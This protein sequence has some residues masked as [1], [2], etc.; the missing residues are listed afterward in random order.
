[1]TLRYVYAKKAPWVL[2]T[3]DAKAALNALYY[4]RHGRFGNLIVDSSPD[5]PA[6][7]KAAVLHRSQVFRSHV[8][9]DRA[10]FGQVAHREFALEH[11]LHHA[12]PD[13]MRQ[14]PQ[15]F[16]GLPEILQVGQF[17]GMC[18]V[19]VSIISTHHDMST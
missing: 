5:L 12:K 17:D 2:R 7:E 14:G 15:T 19:H 18:C 9:G 6:R 16:G 10:R 8:A 11:H 4:S 13:R 3:L 1:M